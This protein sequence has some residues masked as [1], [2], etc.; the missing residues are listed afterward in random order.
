MWMYVP[1]STLNHPAMISRIV[2]NSTKLY[3]VPHLRSFERITCNHSSFPFRIMRW[4]LT[5]QGIPFERG[6]E[7]GMSRLL[8]H[9]CITT[10]RLGDVA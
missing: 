9:I 3:V 2:V 10:W 8:S 5:L 6:S 4:L 7:L 1:T